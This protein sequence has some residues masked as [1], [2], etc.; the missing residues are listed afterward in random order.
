MGR[1]TYNDVLASLVTRLVEHDA[2]RNVARSV[3]RHWRRRLCR[4]GR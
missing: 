3:V 4:G 1:D 2:H